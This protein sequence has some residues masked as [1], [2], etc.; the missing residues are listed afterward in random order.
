V[1]NTIFPE[2][3][4]FL[5]SRCLVPARTAPF[6]AHWVGKF[7][8]FSNKNQDLGSN[9]RVEKFLNNLKSQKKIAE[10]QIKQAEDGLYFLWRSEYQENTELTGSQI[11]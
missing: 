4:D 9:P 5:L 1:A 6:Y 2:F 10:W 8:A 7:L 11:W 3:Q